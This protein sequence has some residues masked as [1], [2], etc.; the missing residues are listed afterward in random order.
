MIHVIYPQGCYGLYLIQCIYIYSNLGNTKDNPQLK[1]SEKTGS[2]HEASRSSKI[3]K[4]FDFFHLTDTVPYK[5]KYTNSIVILPDSNHLLDYMDN[6]FLKQINGDIIDFIK[7]HEEVDKI[8]YKLKKFWN[9]KGAIDYNIPRWILR[10]FISYWMVDSWNFS[11]DRNLY[12]NFPS[13]FKLE[14]NKLFEPKNS[15]VIEVIQNLGL[16]LI[17]S[18]EAIEEQTEYWIKCQKFHNIQK[19][20]DT[21]IQHILSKT[22]Q[23]NPCLTII[24]EAYIQMKFRKL[25]YEIKCQELNVFPVCSLTMSELV[26]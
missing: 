3:K 14:V 19:K 25:G 13:D 7:N 17:C 4:Y 1:I 6:Q 15:A 2:S 26:K 16:T 8:D 21:W 11:Y 23:K 10:E 20:C 9:Y 24:D 18:P 12:E 22:Y 5:S